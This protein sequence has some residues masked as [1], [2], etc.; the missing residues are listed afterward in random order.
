MRRSPAKSRADKSHT[1]SGSVNAAPPPLSVQPVKTVDT[2]QG[3]LTRTSML[4]KEEG[5]EVV[6]DIIAEL[7]DRLMVRC[8]QVFLKR[9]LIPFSVWWAQNIL[10]ETVECLLPMRDEGDDPEHEPFCQENPETHPCAEGSPLFFFGM[11][12]LSGVS[13]AGGRITAPCRRKTEVSLPYQ[14]IELQ[15]NIIMALTLKINQRADS[16]EKMLI[17]NSNTIEDLKTSLNHLYAEIQDIKDDKTKLGEK[18]AQ[19]QKSLV[20]LEE[21]VADAERYKRRWCLRL[22]GL[23]E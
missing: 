1:Y 21:R 5:E 12:L 10:V 8:C 15:E 11:G 19:Q 18:F 3:L 20:S 2:V 14:R 9:Q 16:L 7:M 4:T 23:S 6:V 13:G 17:T 22:Y